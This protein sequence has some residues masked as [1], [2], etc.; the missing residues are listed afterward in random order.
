MTPRRLNPTYMLALGFGAAALALACS[1]GSG[2][3]GPTATMQVI[4]SVTSVAAVDV[5]VAGQTALSN[6]PYGE[7]RS[8]EVPAGSQ[9]VI[10]RPAG[11]TGTEGGSIVS[12]VAGGT[13]TMLTVDSSSII[14][15][16]VLTD[17]GS[18]VP[19]NQSKLRAVHFAPS[20]APVDIWRTQPDFPTPVTFMFPFNYQE[21]SPYI[22]SDPGI[23]TV[24]VSS[25]KWSGGIPVLLDTMLITDPIEVPA[26]ESRTVVILDGESSV[27]QYEVITP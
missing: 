18:V 13:V 1:D 17:T 26:G 27:L 3:S 11:T 10:I 9:E 16:W 20:V 21:S 15:P 22:Q 6:V 12:F 2:P 24:I 23:W 4:H 7:T 19:A 25:K 5:L 14:N 8:A